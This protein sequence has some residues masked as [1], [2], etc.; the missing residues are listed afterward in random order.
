V[1]SL[2]L[3]IEKKSHIKDY[4]DKLNSYLIF[5]NPSDPSI[6]TEVKPAIIEKI[7]ENVR[8]GQNKGQAT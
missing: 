5:D 6:I 8:T 1:L 7:L 4:S 2:G 3:S